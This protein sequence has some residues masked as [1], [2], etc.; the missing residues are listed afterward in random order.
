MQLSF[1]LE[2]KWLVGRFLL[3]GVLNFSLIWSVMT[4]SS[5]H[6]IRLCGIQLSQKVCQ[7]V[8]VY[9]YYANADSMHAN[10]FPKQVP[11]L[12][13]VKRTLMVI[14]KCLNIVAM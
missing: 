7:C 10:L 11:Q 13:M 8:F 6:F 5:L 14:I 9:F 4:S 1:V 2:V 12:H 3:I